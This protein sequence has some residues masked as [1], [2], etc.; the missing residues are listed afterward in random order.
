MIRERW[1]WPQIGKPIRQGFDRE[2]DSWVD[3]VPW[4][5]AGVAQSRRP[6]PH[7][8]NAFD[9]PES[10]TKQVVDILKTILNNRVEDFKTTD[11]GH[12]GGKTE[13]EKLLD[14][15]KNIQERL[16]KQSEAEIKAIEKQLTEYVGSVFTDYEVKFDAKS[17]EVVSDNVDF[18]KANPT[19]LMGPKGGYLSAVADQG[20]GAKRTILW[21][22]LRIATDT[23]S[24][25]SSRPHILLIDEPE[26][27]LHP[28]AIRE[29]CNVLYS[30][31]QTANWQ[32]MITTH[33]P[34]FIDLSKDNTTIIRVEKDE[35]GV[36]IKGTTLYRPSEISLS[37][38]DKENM[39]M[40]NI[41]DP[42][43]AEFF[44]GGKVIVVEGDTEYTA[45]K[46]I[47][48]EK[49]QKYKD[50]HVIRAR[51]KATIV[52]L[53]KI[54]NHFGAG[55]SILHD[56]DKPT[57]VRKG[58]EIVNGAWSLNDN[59]RK[60]VEKS[61]NRIRLVANYINFETAYFNEQA[62]DDK[63]YN[64]LSKIKENP[65]LF[66]IIENLL[67]ALIDHKLPLPDRAIEWVTMEDL[68]SKYQ[69]LG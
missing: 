31:P 45:F 51:G 53:A 49:P 22:A 46:H 47:V 7:R 17:D 67:S 6:E 18:F 28:N 38:D 15:V 60:E 20:S 35:R 4:G 32:V 43:V 21:S 10:Q 64:A 63:P 56:S 24:K 50:I 13:Y 19:L 62:S 14:N 48:A 57:V 39:K 1:L 16:L 23:K 42:Y 66:E 12:G 40:L 3:E 54:L 41:C 11:D 2:Q 59:I 34:Q 69:A 8:V 65:E 58:K 5:A 52:T 33:S 37:P 30:L 26:I 61:T 9:A 36:N 25:K 44:F 29:A 55:Y 68:N 27:C